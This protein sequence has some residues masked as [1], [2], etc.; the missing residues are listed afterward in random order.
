MTA[1]M[2]L[3]FPGQRTA[4]AT[5]FI[6]QCPSQVFYV[7][8]FEFRFISF[9]SLVVGIDCVADRLKLNENYI[10]L[11]EKKEPHPFVLNLFPRMLEIAF[12]GFEISNFLREH[13][14]EP[15]EKGD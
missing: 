9:C 3:S 7:Q 4:T 8:K 1:I 2:D 12:K 5:S 10:F 15:L 11:N 13:A 14:P 6:P